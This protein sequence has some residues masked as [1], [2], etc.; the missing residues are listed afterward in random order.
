MVMSSAR[1]FICIAPS[2]ANTITGR[3]GLPNL[4]PIPYGTPGPI[5]ARL[6]DREPRM[7]PWNLSWRA[8]Q[9]AEEPESAVTM[10]SRQPRRKLVEQPHRVDRVGLHHGLVL[11]GPPPPGYLGLD[12]LL[13]GPVLVALKKR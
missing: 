11:H 2:P 6:P 9:F 13:P 8:Y 7:S 1:P 12:A 5:V 4:A 10:A 3:P